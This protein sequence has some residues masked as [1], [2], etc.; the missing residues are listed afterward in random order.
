MLIIKKRTSTPLKRTFIL[1]F[2]F[3]FFFSMQTL[4]AQN[5]EDDVDDT[6]PAAPIDDYLYIGFIAAVFYGSIILKNTNNIKN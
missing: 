3:L 4:Q 6:A 5:F 1:F 2:L